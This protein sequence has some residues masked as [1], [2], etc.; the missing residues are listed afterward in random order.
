MSTIV[1]DKVR[2]LSSQLELLASTTLPTLLAPRAQIP[3]SGS[4]TPSSSSTAAQQA[5]EEE[6]KQSLQVTEPLIEVLNQLLIRPG[7]SPAS[8]SSLKAALARYLEH[9]PDRARYMALRKEGAGLDRVW[10][11]FEDSVTDGTKQVEWFVVAAGSII[12]YGHMLEQFLNQTL[13]LAE[14]IYYWDSVLTE[15]GGLLTYSIQHA[16]ITIF[17]ASKEIYY[18]A[19][20]RLHRSSATTSLSD[21]I[22]TLQTSFA[23]RRRLSRNLRA[24][25]RVAP[26][27]GSVFKL[28]MSPLSTVYKEVQTKQQK[29]RQLRNIQSAALGI[30]VGESIT[31]SVDTDWRR[32]VERAVDVM[33]SVVR[34]IITTTADEDGEGDGDYG[35]E[36]NVFSAVDRA[37]PRR[38]P[39]LMAERM[40]RI[41]DEFLPV[42][43]VAQRE[44]LKEAGKPKF[45]IR[46][47][48]VCLASVTF[49]G[50]ALRILFNRRASIAQWAQDAAAT[51]MD[52][53]Y[54]WIVEPVKNI[55]STIRHDD[56]AQVAI[57]SRKS[58][59]ADMESLERMV[60]DFA[61]D[62]G[63]GSGAVVTA[64]EISGIKDGVREGDLSTVL[65]VYEQELKSPIKNAVRGELIRTLLIQMQKTKVDVEVAITGIDRLLKSQELVFGFIAALPSSVISWFITKWAARVYTGKGVKS[66]SEQRAAVAR[67]LGNVERMLTVSSA[68][69]SRGGGAGGAGPGVGGSVRGGRGG[70]DGRGG[71]AGGS[72]AG[73]ESAWLTFMDQGLLLCEVHML[74]NSAGILPAGLRA[75]WIRDLGDLE[76][77][78]LGVKR[79]RDTIGRIWRVYGKFFA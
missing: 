52:F 53:W 63:G 77:I 74:R 10:E 42:Q 68:S 45:W 75:D 55:I 9:S 37:R 44:A 15:T 33:E 2:T 6:L 67:T 76:D 51:T 78:K 30:L 35:F 61:V 22:S 41:A 21:W 54:N 27:A 18:D 38:P 48:P 16:P 36:S 62:T 5:D 64:A 19:R 26:Y 14:D 65:R 49:G 72:G 39:Y 70:R 60:V 24:L 59:Q 29:L 56:A 46:Y 1:D 79:Q 34:N 17:S 40:I 73:L 50:T 69:Y 57:V 31:L 3:R 43:A 66:R 47:W 11:G 12:L 32:G 4:S 23:R 20:N 7:G 28:A 58:L 25:T 13:P 8:V 71:D